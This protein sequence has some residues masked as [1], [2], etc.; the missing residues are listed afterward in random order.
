MNSRES[1][2]IYDPGLQPERTLLAWRRTALGITVLSAVCV[3]FT[4]F[5]WGLPAVLIGLVGVI[6]GLLAY[7]VTGHR[8]RRVHHHLVR[9][10]QHPGNGWPQICLSAAALLLGITALLYILLPA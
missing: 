3:R 2:Q 9:T 5:S 1:D 10:D 8:Y 4:A 7:L 6:L